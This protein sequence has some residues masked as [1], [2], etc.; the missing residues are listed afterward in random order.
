M[1]ADVRDL[2]ERPASSRRLSVE[3]P[4][5]G[6]RLEL[7]A[8]PEEAPVRADLLL[9]RVEEG[10]VVSGSLRGRMQ[11]SCARC[12]EQFE[13]EFAV[14]VQELFAREAGPGDDE[15]PL[16]PEGDL[17]L[18]P[19][20]R[21]AVLLAAPFSPLCRPECRGLCPRCGTDLN[22]EACTCADEAVDPRW[23]ALQGLFGTDAP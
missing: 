22:L 6:L 4:V 17:D 20:V 15:Y 5:A 10:I 12:L 8:V 3:E 19:L 9:E 11:L 23:D 21:D 13:G 16:D 1:R 7:A 14:D 2:L 18:D